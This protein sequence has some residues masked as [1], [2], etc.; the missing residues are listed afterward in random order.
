MGGHP[1]PEDRIVKRYYR[2]LDLLMEAIKHT[3]RAY[4][5][6]NSGLIHVSIR[7]HFKAGSCVSGFKIWLSI[8]NP[9]R[10]P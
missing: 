4:V 10:P 9:P 7:V 3:N 6:D 2:S 8:R 5:F 1:V